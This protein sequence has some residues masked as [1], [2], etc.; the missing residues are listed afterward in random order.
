MSHP[1][2]GHMALRGT[3]TASERTPTCLTVTYATCRWN[4][5]MMPPWWRHMRVKTFSSLSRSLPDTFSARRSARA[6]LSLLSISRDSHAYTAEAGTTVLWKSATVE[7]MLDS[8]S[9]V[10]RSRYM[11]LRT[12]HLAEEAGR[13]TLPAFHPSLQ[14]FLLLYFKNRERKG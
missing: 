6:P 5:R 10:L 4:R 13:F 8:R 3:F 9:I 14:I 7:H 1:T 11:A 2:E 12:P